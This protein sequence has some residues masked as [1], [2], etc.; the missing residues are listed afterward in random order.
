MLRH[1]DSWWTRRVRAARKVPPPRLEALE[2]RLVPATGNILVTGIVRF[3][4]AGD[5]ATRFADTTEFQALTLGLDG[6]LP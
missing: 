5:N 3:N 6:K 4:L 1:L 2:D